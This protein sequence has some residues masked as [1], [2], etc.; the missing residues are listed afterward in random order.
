MK[1]YK[2]LIVDDEIDNVKSILNVIVDSGEPFIIYQ[3]LNGELAFKIASSE[4]PDLIISDWEMPGIDGIELTRMLKNQ[5]STSDIPVIICTG[6]MTTSEHLDIALNSG[7]VDYIRKPIDR[8]ELIARAKSMLDMS[9]SRKSLREK[10]RI[11][12]EDNVFIQALIENIP[13]PFVY[14]NLEG[15]IQ[16][17]NQRFCELINCSKEMLQGNSIYKYFD[18][19]GLHYC[20][21]QDKHLICEHTGINFEYSL[22]GNDYMF[23]KS[24]FWG[25]DKEPHGIMCLLTDITE[26]KSVHNNLLESK[27]KELVSTTL[28]LVQISEL[29]NSMIADLSSLTEYTNDKGPE[30]IKR[31]LSK[32]SLSTSE[33][34]WK[35]FEQRFLSVHESFYK[36]LNELFPDLTPGEIKLCA[37][38]RL[39]LSSKDIAAVTF[40]N[41]QSIDMAR[42]R[43]RKKM[44]LSQDENLVDFLINLS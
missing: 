13:H 12:E 37:F 25:A 2:I 18:T 22:N 21:E 11:I 31:A 32:F 29:N 20:R 42:Y 6:V 38:L 33:N 30:I 3:A 4:L 14:Y 35:E 24:L 7:A 41:S 10:F 28:R 5:E 23:S 39:N 40:Q 26:L 8:V 9:D 1:L 36:R 16:S 15:V 43:L 27:K 19:S 34:F 17:F 44:A